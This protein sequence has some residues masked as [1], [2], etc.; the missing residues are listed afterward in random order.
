MKIIFRV[1]ISSSTQNQVFKFW[2]FPFLFMFLTYFFSAFIAYFIF[3][4]FFF[5]LF[6]I[7][8]W[9]FAF[10]ISQYLSLHT[11]LHPSFSHISSTSCIIHFTFHLFLVRKISSLCCHSHQWN[12]LTSYCNCPQY[13][14][15]NFCNV[16]HVWLPCTDLLAV[17]LCLLYGCSAL[18]QTETLMISVF[19]YVQCV[20]PSCV[21]MI[22][23]LVMWELCLCII[24]T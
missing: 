2:H 15:K 19:C 17:L 4:Q 8:S 10:H 13:Q 6:I 23:L 5:L 11:L 16:C 14:T 1:E 12:R 21:H 3:Y 20:S 9:S 22:Q 7:S 24:Q 18:L